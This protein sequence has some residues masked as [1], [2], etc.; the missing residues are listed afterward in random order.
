M[1]KVCLYSKKTNSETY[2]SVYS[3]R[4]KEI[5]SFINQYSRQNYKTDP[6]Q[7]KFELKKLNLLNINFRFIYNK[8]NTITVKDPNLSDTLYEYG[9]KITTSYEK[10][11]I[12]IAREYYE[13]MVDVGKRILKTK[14]LKKDKL[15]TISTEV[16]AMLGLLGKIDE[17]RELLEKNTN[18]IMAE[19]YYKI[20]LDIEQKIPSKSSITKPQQNASDTDLASILELLALELSPN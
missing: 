2:I 6:K 7:H 4:I 1:K 17:G 16:A 18:V 5:L 11:D 9:K 20:M 15:I 14:D 8:I 13:M 3:E 10:I 12:N 19:K